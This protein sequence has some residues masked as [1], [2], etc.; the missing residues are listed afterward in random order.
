MLRECVLYARVCARV[1][2]SWW[3]VVG[4]GMAF[5]GSGGRSEGLLGVGW[6]VGSSEGVKVAQN[7]LGEMTGQFRE[8]E[9]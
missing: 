5:K 6:Y 3:L 7:G 9:S 4:A 8:G 2:G 1:R